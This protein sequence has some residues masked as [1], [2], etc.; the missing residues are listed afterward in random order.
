MVSITLLAEVRGRIAADISDGNLQTLIDRMEARI[1]KAVGHPS[2]ERTDRFVALGA[3]VYAMAPPDFIYV[4]NYGPYRGA[5]G[6]SPIIG[7]AHD[8][9]E[10]DSIKTAA[11]DAAS[12]DDLD[13]TL[14]YTSG[15]N[16]YRA[17]GAFW[18]AETIITWTPVAF[19]DDFVEA[20]IDLVR[21]RLAR[22][23]YKSERAEGG[24]SYTSPDDWNEAERAI[25][26]TL[27]PSSVFA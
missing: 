15:N 2:A 27:A 26:E 18:Q 22:S 8:I 4:D 21:L 7:L 1:I 23:G 5:P 25:I 24:W 16:V 12:A 19:T 14:Y 13:P 17:N 11:S 9:A 10:I 6:Y 3:I 20:T